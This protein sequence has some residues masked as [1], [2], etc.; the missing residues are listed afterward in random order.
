M[1]AESVLAACNPFTNCFVKE[2]RT[3]F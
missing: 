2:E 1:D 3:G